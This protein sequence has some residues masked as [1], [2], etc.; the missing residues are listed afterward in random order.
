[1]GQRPFLAS[2]RGGSRDAPTACAN[3]NCS[4]ATQFVYVLS[5]AND[6]Y[7]FRPDR[8]QFTRIGPLRCPTSFRPNSM[9]IDRKFNQLINNLWEWDASRF[10]HLGKTGNIRQPGQGVNLIQ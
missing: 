8:R 5:E 1:M 10:P 9:A 2:S 6:L 3:H 4:E 7:S